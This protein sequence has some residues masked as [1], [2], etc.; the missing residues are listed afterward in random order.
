MGQNTIKILEDI[1]NKTIDLQCDVV[2]SENARYRSDYEEYKNE[3]ALLIEL[4]HKLYE[5]VP[6]E[7]HH[8]LNE[9]EEH[10]NAMSA[11]NER[12]MFKQGVIAGL[13]DLKFLES[14]GNNIRFL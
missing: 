8:L 10:E 1:V 6:K 5:V 7:F 3:T 2:R 14:V 12:Q 9:Y 11:L 4:Q 13:T